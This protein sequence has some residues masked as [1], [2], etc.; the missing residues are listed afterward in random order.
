M[1]R[2]LNNQQAPPKATASAAAEAAMTCG[3]WPG[4]AAP[5]PTV[6][7]PSNTMLADSATHL[8]QDG[9]GSAS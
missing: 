1:D 8:S 4:N 2:P 9:A 7:T 6:A 5:T 3:V